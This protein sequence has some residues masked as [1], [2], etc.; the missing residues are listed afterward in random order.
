V[1]EAFAGKNEQQVI[2]DKQPISQ[3]LEKSSNDIKK[4]CFISDL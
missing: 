2:K 3:L 4:N 1:E